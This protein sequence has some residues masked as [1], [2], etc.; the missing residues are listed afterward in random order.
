MESYG[1]PYLRRV[2]Q[3]EQDQGRLVATGAFSVERSRAIEMLVRYQMPNAGHFLRPWLRA[4]ILQGASKIKLWPGGGGVYLVFDGRPFSWKRL[5]DPLTDLLD[6]S[7]TPS[8]E[9]GRMLAFGL[10][11]C[12][13]L[14]PSSITISSGRLRWDWRSDGTESTTIETDKS[15]VFDIKRTTRID[16]MWPFS[17]NRESAR[18]VDAA[19]AAAGML[20]VP[21]G[22]GRDTLPA[23]SA[24]KGGQVYFSR[25]KRRV[26]SFA[27]DPFN[28]DGNVHLYRNGVLLEQL[29]RPGFKFL[30]AHIND[31]KLTTDISG[32]SAVQNQRLKGTL[33]L[34]EKQ[35]EQTF[36]IAMR[37]RSKLHIMPAP[38]LGAV[39]RAFTLFKRARF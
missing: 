31:D 32:S 35:A 16:V 27:L 22:A 3:P 20:S 30:D 9:A 34:C 11:A 10:L 38:I 21:L 7:D 37:L 1:Q 4:A 14:T 36:P 33:D 17:A 24:A 12:M 15:E 26:F 18:L 13:R 8:S 25:D 2:K 5:K 19:W 29:L 6:Y 23:R 28:I 39:K